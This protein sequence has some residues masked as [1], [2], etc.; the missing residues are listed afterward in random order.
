MKVL[1]KLHY[2][3]IAHC[4]IKLKNIM[5]TDEGEIKLVDFRFAANLFGHG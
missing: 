4:D 1:I 5:V 3:Q 2:S